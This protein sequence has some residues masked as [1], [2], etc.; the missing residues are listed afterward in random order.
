MITQE[1]GRLQEVNDYG[2]LYEFSNAFANFSIWDGGFESKESPQPFP[3]QTEDAEAMM[4][5]S[6]VASELPELFTDD[7][8]DV[9]TSFVGETCAFC[10]ESEVLI[11]CSNCKSAYYCSKEHQAAHSLI[12]EPSCGN[13]ATPEDAHPEDGIPFSESAEDL[14]PD[15]S[16]LRSEMLELLNIFEVVYENKSAV[17]TWGLLKKCISMCERIMERYSRI[18]QVVAMHEQATALLQMFETECPPNSATENTT[19]SSGMFVREHLKA[20]V[21]EALE[22]VDRDVEES[23]L[24][25]VPPFC[26]VC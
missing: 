2:R 22:R 17:D 11:Q 13:V 24:L 1:P 6:G 4:D 18:P 25:K 16:E 7:F 26:E 19:S 12:H 21:K 10:L 9:S 15:D 5:Q 8:S 3:I 14:A 20:N 23:D